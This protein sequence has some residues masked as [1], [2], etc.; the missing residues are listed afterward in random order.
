MVENI[1]SVCCIQALQNIFTILSFDALQPGPNRPQSWVPYYH[2]NGDILSQISFLVLQKY[3]NM[4]LKYFIRKYRDQTSWLL[5]ILTP[6][7]FL[8]NSILRR[9]NLRG[10]LNPQILIVPLEQAAHTN[11][12]QNF[13]WHCSTFFYQKP[14]LTVTDILILL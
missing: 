13:Y 9:F 12:M 8:F 4:N 11:W 3:Y 14:L 1:I 6:F 5:K 7:K 10:L 2:Q